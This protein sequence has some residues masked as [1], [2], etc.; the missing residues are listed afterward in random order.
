MRIFDYGQVELE[1][2]KSRDEKLGAVIDRI[3][4]IERE[5]TPDIFE[6]IVDCIIAQQISSKAAVTVCSRLREKFGDPNP[7]MLSSVTI[8]DIQKCGIS[9]RKAGYI[10]LLAVSIINGELNLSDLQNLSDDEVIEK[11]ISLKGIG[12]WTAEMLLIF[13]LLR[14]DVLSRNDLGIQRGIRNLYGIN[15]P[16]DEEFD[17]IRKRFSPYCTV[18][19]FYL[20]EIS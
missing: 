8:D 6:A 13:S 5:V 17:T 10:K 9:F 7:A 4:K 12:K 2:L 18:A 16:T 20:W 3:G 14:P 19:S 15:S 1:Y 11:L